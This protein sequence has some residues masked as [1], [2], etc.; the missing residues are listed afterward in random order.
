MLGKIIAILRQTEGILCLV[1]NQQLALMP[2]KIS[3][4]YMAILIDNT[5]WKDETTCLYLTNEPD[6][7]LRMNQTRSTS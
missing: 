1:S 5:T 3:T 6:K 4:P 7:T 2:K